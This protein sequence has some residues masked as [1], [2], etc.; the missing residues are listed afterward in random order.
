MEPESRLDLTV[1]VAD[2]DGSPNLRACLEAVSASVTGLSAEILLVG[3]RPW[4]PDSYASVANVRF[5]P[6]ASNA[7]VP[8]LWAEGIRQAQGGAVALTTAHMT[9]GRN[10]ARAIT[11]PLVAPVAGVG[12]PIDL[13]P[14]AGLVDWAIYYLRY[15]T[16]LPSQWTD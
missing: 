16:F 3:C 4:R 14:G 8:E 7:L 6:A 11:G 12:G 15:S 10:W 9:V 1:V 2:V 5:I 13:A